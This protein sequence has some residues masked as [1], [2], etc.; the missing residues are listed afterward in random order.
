M[1][2][3]RIQFPDGRRVVHIRARSCKLKTEESDG[4]LLW[5]ARKRWAG[6]RTSSRRAGCNR[7]TFTLPLAPWESCAF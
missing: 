5:V 6:E 7:L 1:P 4:A 2:R 3:T